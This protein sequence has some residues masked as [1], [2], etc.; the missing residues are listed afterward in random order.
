MENAKHGFK[1]SGHIS[2]K[3]KALVAS[4]IGIVLLSVWS[5]K[6]RSDLDLAK[7]S[8]VKV[9]DQN[10]KEVAD[11]MRE[12]IKLVYQSI[13]TMSLVPGVRKIDRY[14]KTFQADAKGT[15]QQLYNNA[16]V[17]V[18]VS[19]VYL[20][21]RTLDPDQVDPHTQKPE[22]PIVT[23]DEFAVNQSDK[24]AEADSAPK[25]EEVEI[26]E[27]RLM[28]K[29]LEYLASTYPTNKEFKGLEI[30]AVSGPE[31]VTC[32]NAEFTAKD[33]ASKDDSKRKGIVM[34]VPTYDEKGNFSG[35]VSAVV[36]TEVLKHLLGRQNLALVNLSHAYFATTD[37]TESW[38]RALPYLQKGQAS[39]DLIFSGVKKVD[40]VD[41]TEWQVWGLT[42]NQVFW[43]MNE[44]VS[45]KRIFWGG[46]AFLV[47][48]WLFAMRS[49]SNQD[50]LFKNISATIALLQSQADALNGNA[51]ALDKSSQET[52]DTIQKQAAAAERTASSAHEIASM[53]QK[54]SDSS[55]S[56][57]AAVEQGHVR[58]TQGQESVQKLLRGFE[59]IVS[60]QAR[61][62]SR[63]TQM[64]K[65]LRSVI[66]TIND[67]KS[68]TN[69]INHIV[70]QTKLLSFNASV[71]AARAG[72]QGKGFSVVAEEVG[73]LANNSG[74]AAK[75]ISQALELGTQKISAVIESS[76]KEIGDLIAMGR[77]TIEGG[78]TSALDCQSAFQ[79]IFD[80]IANIN[81][82]ASQIDAA[83]SEQSVG[84][85][86]I[87][88]AISVI[89]QTADQSREQSIAGREISTALVNQS[90]GLES[91]IAQLRSLVR[92]AA[93]GEAV[94]HDAGPESQ[95]RRQDVSKNELSAKR[96]PFKKVA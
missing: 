33:L 66:D 53:A 31:V 51:D 10:L 40:V 89:S 58:S 78:S 38:A 93:S 74:S 45:L 27:Y 42:E 77:K 5:F 23:F 86:E 21:P 14:A 16:Y 80:S 30:P 11:L 62:G 88:Q 48:A 59:E 84:V 64:A 52:M 57:K 92:A 12:K 82:M 61:L 87:T 43:S 1:K 2:F 26:E 7:K 15:V 49:L 67:I 56:M 90:S 81:S 36:R 28:K 32:D 50:K 13:R 39:P 8:F 85:T 3:T 20:L 60:S 55:Q 71:E 70:F 65:E 34:T 54:T 37:T 22:E 6:Y 94:L 35:G 25:L 68:K 79:E 4:G 17:N 83:A 96:L 46:V 41:A 47:L 63:F 19:E 29:Q 95:E 76:S 73:L 18:Q 44:I 9:E 72:D 69:V 91:V 24:K 75:E